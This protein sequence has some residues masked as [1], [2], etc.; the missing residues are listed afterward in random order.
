MEDGPCVEEL[1]V[2]YES[3]A[4]M[5]VRH[6]SDERLEIEWTVGPIPDNYGVESREVII[7]YSVVGDAPELRPATK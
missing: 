3:W 2:T 5:V 4:T 1:H 7:R 6:Y